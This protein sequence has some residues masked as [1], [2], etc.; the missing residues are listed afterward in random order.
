MLE[1]SPVLAGTFDA[2]DYIPAQLNFPTGGASGAPA[3]TASVSDSAAVDPRRYTKFDHSASNVGTADLS[4]GDFLD[5]INPLQHIPVVSSVYRAITGDT[6]NPVSRVAGDILYGGALGVFSAL[7]SGAGA[8]ADSVMEA[9]TGKDMTGT[10]VAALFGD[11]K[12]A[13]G[14][15]TVQIASADTPPTPSSPPTAAPMAVAE[16]DNP[17]VPASAPAFAPAPAAAP[18]A[19]PPTQVAQAIPLNRN[20]LPFGGAMA[21][22][23]SMQEQNMA[24]AVSSATGLHVGN[25]IYTSRL[26]NGPHPLPVAA[27]STA[28]VVAAQPPAPE[29]PTAAIAS[30]LP[31]TPA[32]SSG[33]MSAAGVPVPEALSD[34]ALILRALNMYRN[35]AGSSGGAGASVDILN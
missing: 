11:E 2:P 10:V 21:P 31:S 23:K 19:N 9:K 20:K 8:I 12:T 33:A 15:G 32:P 7:A 28:P 29:M 17:P 22:V 4:F 27:T 14:D 34:D 30:S 25:T 24:M 5:L 35:V 26:M 6:I 18:D 13:A 16:A 1:I 3:D